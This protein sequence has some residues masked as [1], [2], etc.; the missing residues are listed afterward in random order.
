MKKRVLE[1]EI[2]SPVDYE[3]LVA[4]IYANEVSLQEVLQLSPE[5]YNKKWGPGSHYFQ[6]D[7][8]A[9]IHQEEGPDKLKVR[10]TEYAAQQDWDLDELLGV[11]QQAKDALVGP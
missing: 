4:Y 9:I 5:E 6:G 2:G 7:E 8:V 3:R 1:A 11:I 10:F